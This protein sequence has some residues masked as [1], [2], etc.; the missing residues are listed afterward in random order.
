MKAC[1]FAIAVKRIRTRSARRLRIIPST[2]QNGSNARPNRALAYDARPVTG[3]EGCVT[4]FDA[5]NIGDG[6]IRPRFT[7][8]GDTKSTKALFARRCMG[9]V[10]RHP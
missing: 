2:R 7:L 5:S 1:Q 3:N 8:D 4:H 9:P 6:I 10:E